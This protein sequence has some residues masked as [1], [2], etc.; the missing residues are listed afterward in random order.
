MILCVIAVCG[1]AGSAYAH[2][3]LNLNVR[4]LHV[5]HLADGIRVYLRT[6]MPY[7][8]AARM[9][10]IGSDGQPGA[11]PYTI[12]RIEEGTLV[13]YLDA[14]RLRD[15]PVG[16]GSFASEGFRLV[17]DGKRLDADVEQVRVSRVG[18][19]PDFATLNEAKAA[20]TAGPPVPEPA[21]PP[22]VGDAVVDV[23]LHYRSGVPISSYSVSST[24]DPGLPGQENTANL[25]LDYSPGGTKVFRARGLLTDPVTI[26]RSAFAAVLTFTKEGIRHILEGADHVLFVLCLVLGAARLISLASRITGFTIGHSITLTAGF[27][28][29]VP[30]GAWFIPT[31]DIG[32]ALSIIYAA[33]IAAM[34]GTSSAGRERNM[35]F[36]TLAIGLL[37]G[38]SFSFV[39]HKILQITSP[40]IWQ[41]LLAFNV[42][43]EIGQLIIILAAWSVFRLIERSSNTAWRIGR[44]GIALACMTVAVL[45]TWQ[46]AWSLIETL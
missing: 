5:E 4:I 22:Y 8:V 16:L 40:D 2:F 12:N 26:S 34:P 21:N 19:Q 37:H 25:I 17:A 18:T 42:G 33:A 6:P 44:T 27:F 9:G 23:V 28:G 41:S 11:A 1:F 36:V 20:F 29:F 43:V 15:D 10:P 24:L 3:L 35:F 31:V 30:S 32:I 45:W 13:H 14:A 38:L 39:L 7:L 46:R